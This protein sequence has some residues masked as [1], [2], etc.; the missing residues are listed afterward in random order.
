MEGIAQL[1]R[2]PD[3]GSGGRG[4]EPHYFPHLQKRVRND[5][6]FVLCQNKKIFIKKPPMEIHRRSEGRKIISLALIVQLIM[7]RQLLL[8]SDLIL[9]L[10]SGKAKI[11]QTY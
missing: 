2:A 7:L 1:V 3:C 10:L 6:L 4:F 9:V 8:N 11:D 5:S